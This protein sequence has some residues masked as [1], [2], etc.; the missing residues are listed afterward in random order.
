MRNIQGD[1]RKALSIVPATNY[2]CWRKGI[3]LNYIKMMWQLFL[4]YKKGNFIGFSLAVMIVMVVRTEALFVM[5]FGFSKAILSS[6]TPT[7]GPTVQFQFWH[8]SRWPQT[9]RLKAKSHETAPTSDASCKWEPWVTHTSVQ[10]TPQSGVP[11]TP[12]W[13]CYFAGTHN[14]G[15]HCT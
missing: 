2:K 9:H 3:R 14:S 15:K 1:S 12:P 11:A 7:G 5:P 10:L 8:L 13:G 4:T 6:L